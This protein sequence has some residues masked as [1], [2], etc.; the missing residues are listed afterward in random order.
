MLCT[1]ANLKHPTAQLSPWPAKFSSLKSN[2][3]VKI[4]GEVPYPTDLYKTT[5]R[6]SLLYLSLSYPRAHTHSYSHSHSHS[7][8]GHA[9][10]FMGTTLFDLSPFS[11][12]AIASLFCTLPFSRRYTQFICTEAPSSLSMNWPVWCL[13]AALAETHT[14]HKIPHSLLQ[15]AH[16]PKAYTYAKFYMCYIFTCITYSCACLVDVPSAHMHAFTLY[17]QSPALRFMY[18]QQ[19]NIECC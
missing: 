2:I 15:H 4:W 13:Y 9:E 11:S 16:M 19:I 1:L 6:R 17:T 3:H 10:S 7:H 12:A 5:A 14:I 8:T 18:T